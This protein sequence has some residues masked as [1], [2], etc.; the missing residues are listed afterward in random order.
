MV[1]CQGCGLALISPLGLNPEER[2]GQIW[3][4]NTA[5][6]ISTRTGASM[7]TPFNIDKYHFTIRKQ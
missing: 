2:A 4:G 6:D 5:K 1:Y 3:I 7:I